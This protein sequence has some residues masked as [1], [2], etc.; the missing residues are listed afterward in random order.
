MEHE[1]DDGAVEYVSDI[2]E[3]DEDDDIDD[4]ESWLGSDEDDAEDVRGGIASVV[5]WRTRAPGPGAKRTVTRA[6]AAGPAPPRKLRRDVTVPSAAWS[7][8]STAR[9]S[10]PRLL[11]STTS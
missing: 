2:E 7:T 11:L 10:G 6:P 4:I 9:V 3:S 5:S 8:R 1:E